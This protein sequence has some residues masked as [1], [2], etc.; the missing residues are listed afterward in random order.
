[1]RVRGARIGSVLAALLVCASGVRAGDGLAIGDMAPMK[2]AK[3]KNVDGQEVSIGETA[4]EKG[5]LVIFTCNQCPYAKAWEQ[6]LTEIGN[7]YS[8][9][10]VG[11]I[12]VN[13]NDPKV[14]PGDGF[15]AMK[16]RASERGMKFP[17]VVDATSGVAKAFGATR[18]PEA[19]LFDATGK[20]VYHGTID[21]N[22][23]DAAKVKSSFLKN[24]LDAVLAG[25]EVPVSQTKALGCGI[26]FR[27]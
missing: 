24:A 10:G 20:L 1:M 11:V 12:A 2:D 15:E 9:R 25:K 3:L 21:D 13:A 22:Y 6:R 14:V 5:T 27:S 23:E 16:E 19:F 26:K 17:Y 18:T 7:T 4:G 8:A